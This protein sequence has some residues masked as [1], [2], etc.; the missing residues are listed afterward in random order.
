MSY[1]VKKG[2][3]EVVEFPRG[4]VQRMHIV[5]AKIAVSYELLII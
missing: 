5:F 2:R 1:Q 4:E 3:D